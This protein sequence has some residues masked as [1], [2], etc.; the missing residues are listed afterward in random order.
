MASDA[1]TSTPAPGPD[2]TSY[3]G[4]LVAR[5]TV[6]VHSLGPRADEE[7]REVIAEIDAN[8]A[9]LDE[10][11]KRLSTTHPDDIGTRWTL[12]YVAN[13]L[14]DPSGVPWFTAVAATPLPPDP[15]AETACESRTSSEV[16]VRVMA[17]EGLVNLLAV[18]KDAAANGLLSVIER[19]SNVSVRAAAGQGLLEHDPTFRSAVVDL[20]PNDQQFIVDLRRIPHTELTIDEDL[21]IGAGEP[22]DP[23]PNLD[24]VGEGPGDPSGE[25]PV[26]GK[27]YRSDSGHPGHVHDKRE[28]T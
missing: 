24:A 3:L 23:P 4:Q 27:P 9:G 10:I 17:T 18:D 5:A 28:G 21:P 26:V 20:L 19:Q 25:A 15:D 22:S 7:L 6:L 14:R 13:M 11:R 12:L 1:L 16:L 8:S 2:I